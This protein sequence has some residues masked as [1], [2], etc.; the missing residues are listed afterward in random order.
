[1]LQ[2]QI[3]NENN[4][5]LFVIVK[6]SSTAHWEHYFVED[7]KETGV[8]DEFNAAY[9]Y[10]G[11]QIGLPFSGLTKEQSQEWLLKMNEHNPSVGYDICPL[12][13]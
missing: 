12:I 7:P 5:P 10:T 2:N 1:L 4:E 6:N 8:V 9:T 13:N 11:K 3:K